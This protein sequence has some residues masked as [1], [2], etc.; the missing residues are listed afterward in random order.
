MPSGTVVFCGYPN[1]AERLFDVLVD[2]L[3]QSG[4]GLYIGDGGTTAEEHFNRF[5][6][7]QAHYLVCGP[8]AEEGRNI[9]FAHAIFHAHVP[10]NPNRLEQ[11]IGRLLDWFGTGG[12]VSGRVGRGTREP[13]GGLDRPAS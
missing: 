12:K 4:V 2:E 13:D 3:G 6:R 1:A 7:G 8:A 9:Q 11:R 10:W 5:A